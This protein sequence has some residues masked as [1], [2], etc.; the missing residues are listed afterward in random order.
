M[1]VPYS[2][3]MTWSRAPRATAETIY[4]VKQAEMESEPGGLDNGWELL[5]GQSQ[6]G[7][8]GRG[9]EMQKSLVAGRLNLLGWDLT[10]A[11]VTSLS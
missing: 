1:A 6:Q 10:K 3:E 7:R 9:P 8:P 5:Q 11:P 4:R 2:R